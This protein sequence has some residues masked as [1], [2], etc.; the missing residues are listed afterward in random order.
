MEPSPNRNTIP[1]D[2]VELLLYVVRARFL[3][4]DA[5]KSNAIVLAIEG[6]KWLAGDD[7][8]VTRASLEQEEAYWQTHSVV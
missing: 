1:I 6:L 7:S 8:M 3:N 4:L 5:D 2:D